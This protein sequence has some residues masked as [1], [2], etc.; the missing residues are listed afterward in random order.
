MRNRRAWLFGLVAIAAAAFGPPVQAQ[1]YPSHPITVIAPFAGGSA[2]DVVLRIMLE[3]AA[4]SLG[5]P[6]VVDNRPGA[7]GNIGTLAGAKAAP[8]GYTLVMSSIGP[9]AANRTLYRDL[10]YDPEKD[11]EPILLFAHLPNIVVVST[12]LPI[13]TLAEFVAYAKAHP[14]ELNYGSV[15]IGS[16]QHLAAAY[17][18]QVAGIQMTH[19]PYRNIAQYVP[20]MIAGTVPVGFQ[21]FPNVAA[22]LQSGNAIPLAVTTGKRMTLFPNVPTVAEAGIA[23]YETSG[24][25]ALLAPRGTP[26]PI[27]DQLNKEMNA[28]LADPA[29]RQR[30]AEQ[31]AEAAGGT[32]DELAKFIVSETA[33]WREIITKGGIPV[34]Q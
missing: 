30:M 10:G 7:G 15:G 18:E 4:K 6:I 2:S 27:V 20:D 8:D 3:R 26:K 1:P 21:W 17:F 23:G 34:I 22:A 29:V 31:G 33:K 5:Q 9:L 13:K 24:W 25:L 11:L 19:V 16:S 12:K 28:A 14:K 32:P